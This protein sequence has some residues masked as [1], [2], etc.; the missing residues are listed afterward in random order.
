MAHSIESRPPFLDQELVELVLALPSDAIV[1]DGWSR[2]ILRESLSGVLPELVRTRRKKIGFTTPEI[3][4]L[5]AQRAVVQ[6]IFRSP[7]CCSRP[8]WDAPAIARAFRACCDGE[9]EESPFFWRVLNAEAWLRVFHGAAPLAPAGARPRQSIQRAGDETTVALLAEEG[10]DAEAVLSIADPECKPARVRVRAGRPYGL[11]TR[12]RSHAAGRSR[13]RPRGGADGG[14]RRCLWRPSRLAGRRCRRHLREGGRDQSGSVVSCFFGLG[15]VARPPAEPLRQAL[16][17]RDRAGHTR[18][19]AARDRRSR[20]ETDPGG[21]DCRRRRTPRRRERHLLPGRRAGGAGDRRARQPGRCHRTI[22][23]PSWRRPTRTAWPRSCPRGSRNMRAG[24][25]R[26]RSSTRTTGGSTFS[27]R[28]SPPRRRP[29]GSPSSWRG[30]SGT[31]R[32]GRA[33]SRLRL[34]CCA[35]SAN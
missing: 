20:A 17:G 26:W 11:G 21:L 35:V 16:A 34:R 6:G 12:A 33:P 9:L 5:R 7:A 19:D 8:F 1:R 14:P 24:S 15:R 13:R 29:A 10:G 18:D 23:T 3:R 2:W 25:S 28:A 22:P 4:W 27:G 30:S 31:I 32:S